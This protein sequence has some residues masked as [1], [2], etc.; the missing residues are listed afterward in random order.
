MSHAVADRQ[1]DARIA[2]GR[3]EPTLFRKV[4]GSFATGVTVITTQLDGEIRGMTANAFMS[5]SLEPPLC[6]IS[7][8]RSARMHACLADAGHFGVSILGQG[9]R[10]L[11]EHFAGRPD[12]N[13]QVDFQYMGR[14]PILAD[15]A[16]SI[17]ADIVATHACGDHTL[18]IGHIV[19]LRAAPDR[20]LLVHGGRYATL[21]HSDAMAGPTAE[22]W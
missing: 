3:I 22:F 9:Q 21:A 8:A 12:A 10:R 2:P 19:G 14:T 15:T 6:V 7:V 16:C 18:F 13:L 17:A 20:P 1:R 11:S 4:M 5:G